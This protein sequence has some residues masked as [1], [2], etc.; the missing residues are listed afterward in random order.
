MTD[1]VAKP[2]EA[3]SNMTTSDVS[4]T[5]QTI[6]NIGESLKHAREKAK[7]STTDVADKLNWKPSV[8]VQIE[9]NDFSA[10]PGPTFIR[11]YLRAYGKL[12]AL[13]PEALIEGYNQCAGELEKPEK[14]FKPVDTIKPQRNLS[15]PLIKYT[16]LIIVAAL[17][18]LSVIW[19]QSRNGAETLSLT[20]NETVEIETSN[21][22]TIIAKM[23]LSGAE[24]TESTA[25]VET[26][27]S[28]APS[29]EAPE[30][31]AIDEANL[32][33]DNSA[34]ETPPTIQAASEDTD[35]SEPEPEAHV[36]APGEEK[37]LITFSQECWVEMTDARGI[38]LI[39]NL[40]KAGE[41]SLASGVAPFKLMIG[42]AQG[43]EVT[44]G[45][46]IIDLKPYTNRNGIARLTLGQ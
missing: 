39:A 7:L 15:D 6:L 12:V 24:D 23:D 45:D 10:L 46:K 44:Y 13:D 36:L 22:E 18:A 11:G 21:G 4:S 32:I 27:V 41:Q 30:D 19:W 33:D 20:K 40:K 17:I 35:V 16:T 1:I 31:E 14:R 34:D 9:A 26:E 25:S 38:K 2:E 42:N 37:I 5:E 3:S 43:A 28:P 29:E 8:V